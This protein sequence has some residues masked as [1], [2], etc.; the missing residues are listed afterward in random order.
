M[1]FSCTRLFFP[2]PV[3][4]IFAF[5]KYIFASLIIIVLLKCNVISEEVIA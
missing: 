2:T 3:N 5:R 4:F 1:T